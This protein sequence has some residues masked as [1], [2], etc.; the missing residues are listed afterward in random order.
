MAYQISTHTSLTGRD[1]SGHKNGN[2]LLRISTHT[3]LTGRDLA[4]AGSQ[5]GMT[6]STHTSLTGRDEMAAS[7]KPIYYDFFSHVPH[8]T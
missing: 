3:S 7:A 2:I 5:V 8:G 6:I 1:C 4:G